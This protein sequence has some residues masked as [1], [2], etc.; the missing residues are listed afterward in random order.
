MAVAGSSR[1][2]IARRLNDEFGISDASAILD[3]IGV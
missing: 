2:E 1:E 3:E